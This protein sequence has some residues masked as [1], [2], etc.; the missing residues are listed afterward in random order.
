MDLAKKLKDFRLDA[1][2]SVENGCMGILGASGCGKSMTLKAVAGLVR[3]DAGRIRLGDRVLFDRDKKVDL[4][5]QKRRV[6]Y[7]FQNYALFP[8]MTVE[9]NVAAGIPSGTGDKKERVRKM[10]QRFQLEGMEK[11]YPARLSGGQQQR[12]ALA[13]IFASDVSC[14]LLDEP[15]SAMDSYLRE[16][17]GME[18][19]RIIREFAGCMVL[20]SHDRDE[21][22]RLCSQ[23]LI[24]DRGRT[25]IC[26]PTRELFRNPEKLAAARLTG[27]KNI[28]RIQK[29]GEHQIYAADW[30]LLLWT[31]DRVSD[32]I[33]HAGI[34][35]HDISPVPEGAAVPNRIQVLPVQWAD[36]PFEWT[37][38]FQNKEKPGKKLWMKGSGHTEQIPEEAA[39]PPD[40]ILLLEE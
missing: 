23:T 20:V 14:I 1:H 31:A 36:S 19:S 29:A 4:P 28:T 16:E 12:T 8:N 24:M 3:P 10:M 22:F 11:Q 38:I 17:M 15:F 21:I 9:E 35:A 39:I 18:L 13:R 32:S 27:C 5:P 40:K 33:T 7:L 26:K 30:N 37:C 34:R 25:V 2:F 6:G